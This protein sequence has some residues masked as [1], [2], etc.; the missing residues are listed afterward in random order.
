M[1]KGSLENHLFKRDGTTGDNTHVSTR[2]VGTQSYTALEYVETGCFTRKNDVYSFCAVLL[3]LLSGRR[4]MD[5]ARAGFKEETLV[6]WGKTI[7][8]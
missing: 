5:D 8:K 3:E 2:V 4:A 6:E 7:P 1:P